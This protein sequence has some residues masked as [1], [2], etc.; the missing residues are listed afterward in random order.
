MRSRVGFIGHCL[1]CGL[2]FATGVMTGKALYVPG[3]T[4]GKE[5]NPVHAMSILIAAIVAIYVSLVLDRHKESR[6]VLRDLLLRK[7]DTLSTSIDHILTTIEPSEVRLADVHLSLK[8]VH[9]RYAD[10]QRVISKVN[11]QSGTFEKRFQSLYNDLRV[12]TTYLP[13][14][15]NVSEAPPI[16]CRKGQVTYSTNRLTEIRNAVTLMCDCICTLQVDIARE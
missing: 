9:L 6:K 15:P 1:L 7:I 5:I 2:F 13:I 10:L 11:A 3:V 14:G 8:T 4:W 12:L 16:R